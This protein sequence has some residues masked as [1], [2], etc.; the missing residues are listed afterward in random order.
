MKDNSI[1]KRHVDRKNSKIISK[2]K[3]EN[4]YNQF[5]FPE[6]SEMSLEEGYDTRK[7]SW[8]KNSKTTEITWTDPYIF[9]LIKH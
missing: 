1:S 3:H 2:W 8:Y 9:F 5:I 6:Y 7:R 4:R